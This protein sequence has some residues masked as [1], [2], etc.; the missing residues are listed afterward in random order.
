MAWRQGGWQHAA[1]PLAATFVGSC[2]RSRTSVAPLERLKILMQIQ[3]N[4]KQYTGVVQ[5]RRGRRGGGRGPSG[6]GCCGTAWYRHAG[7]RL[8]LA[9]CKLAVRRLWGEQRA[10]WLPLTAQ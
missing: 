5:V 2:C 9:G 4:E 7:M 10:E 6:C 1:Y 8:A 3:G